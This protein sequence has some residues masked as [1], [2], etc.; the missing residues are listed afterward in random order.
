MKFT[1]STSALLSQ[2]QIANGAIGNTTL[3]IL[4]D[5]LFTIKD[6]SLTIAATDLETSITSSMDVMAS[7]EGSIAIPARI[8]LDTLKTLPDQPLTFEV[9][10]ESYTVEIISQSGKYKL[11]G[12]PGADFP[13]IP[14]VEADASQKI[15]TS[16]LSRAIG[17]TLFAVSSD[18]LRPA[19]TG[20]FVKL[21]DEGM[22]FVSTDAS[23]L[24]KYVY[25]TYT[26]ES[27]SQFIIPQKAMRLLS[28]ALP[29]G[30]TEVE[31]AYNNTNAFFIFEGIKVVCRLIDA[32]YPNYEVVIPVDNPNKLTINR[33]DF[34]NALKRIA[35][36]SNKTTY[37]VTLNIKE[38]ELRLEAKDIDYANEANE[39]MTCN[40]EGD[41]IAIAFNARFLI[42]ILNVLD[43]EEVVLNFSYPSKASL[44]LPTEE[45]ENEVLTMLVMPIMVGA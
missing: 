24:V 4:E 18:E 40:Y 22:T 25:T 15:S 27:A 14:E 34:Q 39:V 10:M 42:D 38:E 2:L 36:F 43:T 44:I 41:D 20:V 8:L 11:A 45:V 26:S 13:I 1:V 3:P 30:D 21:D 37:Q 12:E 31:I 6:G 35:I 33:S 17:K 16:V 28:K 9:N 5:F 29:S 7:D 32:K 19:M 23:K